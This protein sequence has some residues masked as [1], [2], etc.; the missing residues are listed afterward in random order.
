MIELKLSDISQLPNVEILNENEFQIA[1][2]VSIDSRKIESNSIFVAIKGERF[3][4][5][6]F[7][8]D[9]ISKGIAAVII[10]KSEIG[11]FQN[12]KAAIIAVDDTEN[13]FG[14]LAKIWLR[15]TNTK[16]ISITGSNGKTTTKDILTTL[17]KSKFNVVNTYKNNNNHIGVPLTIFEAND[18]TDFLVLEHGTNHFGEI[19]YTAEIAMPDYALITNI[20]DS[21][22]EFLNDRNGVLK[23]KRALLDEADIKDGTVFINEDDDLL[24]GIIKNYKNIITFGTGSSS[25]FCFN[26]EKY[27]KIGRPVISCNKFDE[28]IEL[29]LY[30]K[31][32]ALNFFCASAIAFQLGLTEKEIIS[33]TKKLKP[34]NGRIEVE[35]FKNFV[36]IDDTYNSNPASVKNSLEL[37]HFIQAEKKI[38]VLG[39]MFELGENKVKMH[40]DLA[41][42]IKKYEIDEVLLV[43]S[44]MKN[45][46]Q[47]LKINSV[48]YFKDRKE[49]GEYLKKI[50]LDQSAVLVKGSRGMKM[51]EFV[52]ILKELSL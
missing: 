28:L 32:S 21:H 39:D 38:I 43:G 6:D 27:D 42:S 12:E 29:P 45:L 7:I 36:L 19:K 23:E 22:L 35:E 37:L 44:L 13:A 4:G 3:D 14:E 34:V 5:H 50:E 30:G 41:G 2:N 31:A 9:V 49:L 52:N 20:G 25:D 46:A 24:N 48:K 17:L 10:N 51:E 33:E 18:K 40:R 8:K 47:E 15:K 16:V 1:R 11:R 26:I